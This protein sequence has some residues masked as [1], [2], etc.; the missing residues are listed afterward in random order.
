M[1]WNEYLDHEEGV[2][3]INEIIEMMGQG[4]LNKILA[5]VK[6]SMY[7][8]VIA[9]EASNVSHNE[10]LSLSIRW[11]D[12]DFTFMKN[13]NTKAMFFANFSM[14]TAEAKLTMVQVIR[15]ELGMGF[16]P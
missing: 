12:C 15:V 4:V 1:S 16:K 6:A 2:V 13:A 11:V 10:H 3:I 7:F 5:D 8:A 9:D 14:P